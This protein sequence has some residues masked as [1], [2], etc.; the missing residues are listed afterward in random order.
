MTTALGIPCLTCNAGAMHNS[1]SQ[2]VSCACLDL[3]QMVS[4]LLH[5]QFG[6]CMET[7]G[8]GME[9]ICHMEVD[10]YGDYWWWYGGFLTW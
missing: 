1:L 2:L 9:M 10:T 6:D 5:Q 7:V 8:C 3:Q 4:R